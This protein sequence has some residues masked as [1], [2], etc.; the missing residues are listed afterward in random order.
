MQKAMA[1][2]KETNVST[3]ATADCCDFKVAQKGRILVI[4]YEAAM[5]D[6]HIYVHDLKKQQRYI[7]RRRLDDIQ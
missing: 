7:K 1:L 4:A 6:E 3:H 2:T 5:F